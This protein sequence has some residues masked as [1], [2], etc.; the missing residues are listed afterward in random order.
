MSFCCRNWIKL[1]LLSTLAFSFS[2]VLVGAADDEV[3]GG[4]VASQAAVSA[5]AKSI[6]VK[7]TKRLREEPAVEVEFFAALDSGDLEI[8]FIPRDVKEATVI[9]RN[10]TDKPMQVKLPETFGALPVLAQGFGGGMGGGGMGGGGMGGMGGGGM[11]GGG[12]GQGMGGGMGGGGM[13]GM[14]GGG[15]GGGGGGMFR[16]EAD[17]PRKLSAATVCLEEG[18][19]DPNP[20]MKYRIVRLEEVNPSPEVAEVCK[21]LG[22]GKIAQTTAQAA[23]WHLANGLSWDKLSTLPRVVSKYTG[24]EYYFSNYEIQAAIR[25]VAAVKVATSNLESDYEST[26]EGELKSDSQ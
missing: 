26:S 15:M 7:S 10:V 8:D 4:P 25:V 3:T 19:P 11:G 14:G 5:K 16:V 2:P 12:G 23:A 18:K 9:F 24:V 22:Y 21:A 6:P 20:R 17:K 1:S 13:G